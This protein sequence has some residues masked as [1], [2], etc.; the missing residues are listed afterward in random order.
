MF[1][2]VVEGLVPYPI[3]LVYSTVRD[4]ELT[5]GYNDLIK[6]ARWKDATSREVCI[7]EVEIAGIISFESEYFVISEDAPNRFEAK[8]KSG[9]IEFV[10]CYEF[11]SKSEGTFV[12][13]SDTMVLHGLLSFSEPILKGLMKSGMTEN[14]KR[15]EELLHRNHSKP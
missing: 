12:R 9:S 4:L 1:K 11:E 3:E 2:T 15:L 6:K 13:V 5:V 10:D 8:C 14:F 7:L